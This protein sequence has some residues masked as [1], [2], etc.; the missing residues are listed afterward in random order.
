[1]EVKKKRNMVRV[2]VTYKNSARRF[3]LDEP[4]SFVS[5]LRKVESVFNLEGFSLY[6][7]DD[8]NELITLTSQEDFDEAILLLEEM[9]QAVLKIVA[10]DSE[11]GHYVSENEENLDE[12][13]ESLPSISEVIL[14]LIRLAE[15]NEAFRQDLPE[16]SKI[17]VQAWAERNF[18]LKVVVENIINNCPNIAN[19][20]FV[21]SLDIINNW[22]RFKEESLNR[23]DLNSFMNSGTGLPGCFFSR[24]C[25]G[26][27]A[28]P[29]LFRPF[30][31]P[32]ETLFPA[33][34]RELKTD[35][36]MK[37]ELDSYFVD[38]VNLPD[39]VELD[40]DEGKFHLKTWILGN[41][42]SE[43]WPDGTKLVLV[44]GDEDIVYG[45]KSFPVPYAAPGEEVEVS[46]LLRPVKRGKFRTTFRLKDPEGNEF[47]HWLW[48]EINVV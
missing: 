48:V 39:G 33:F 30:V 27:I 2:K 12:K 3:A 23:D 36:V 11:N 6:Y 40:L 24:T 22:E 44:G 28:Y 38:D 45:T 37:S 1:V 9:G 25:D 34:D 5:L 7:K 17:A 26:T 42:G 8:E 35:T 41:N 15:E 21:S 43:A 19:N 4:A 18:Q 14:S 16:A 29:R 47:G 10:Q 31:I 20:E 46:A 13:E 32:S